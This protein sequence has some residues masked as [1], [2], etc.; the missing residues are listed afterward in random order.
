M[1]A[2]SIEA[3]GSIITGV[4]DRRNRTYRDHV[5]VPLYHVAEWLATNWWHIWYEVADSREQR[6][7]FEFR[8]SL[9]FAGDGFVLPNLQIVPESGRMHLRWSRYRPQHA[10]IEFVDQSETIVER[11]QL[12]EQL[13]TIVEAVL[14]RI[15]SARGDDS[16]V[17]M[18]EDAWEAVNGLDP[19]EQEFTRAA[20]LLGIDPYEV[21]DAV[22][23]A[24]IS[25]WE[26]EDPSI[27]EDALAS[28]SSEESLA[29]V[30][31]WLR[32]SFEILANA[33]SGSDWNR[34]RQSMAANPAGAPWTRGYELARCTRSELGVGDG[35]FE[36]DMGGGLAL[37]HSEQKPPSSRIH[38][39]V[40]PDAPACVTAPRGVLG[41]RF[42]LARALGDYLD[43]TGPGAGI[44]SSLATDRQALSRAFAAEFLAPA[45]SLR[46]AF[47]DANLVEPEQ[48]DDLGRIFGV[49]GEVIRRQIENHNLA[50][51]AQV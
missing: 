33:E 16:S 46:A 31:Q 49:A 10:R 7:D 42:L 11:S 6:P 51:V 3:G 41:T 35:R 23:D 26:K 18:L 28:A 37:C 39:L 5:I 15:R 48:V 9:A 40:A 17:R 14:E 32:Q 36:F 29:G 34:L 45:A 27:R 25:F 20:A 43:R 19:E 21:P 12:E 2:L 38:G 30:S 47:G 13:R 50:S 8:H 1:A 24:I 44:L 22:A 4:V